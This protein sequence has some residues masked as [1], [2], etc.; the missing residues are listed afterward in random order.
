[1]PVLSKHQEYSSFLEDEN[2]KPQAGRQSVP[3]RH[4]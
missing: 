1:L 2:F 3:I 4:K